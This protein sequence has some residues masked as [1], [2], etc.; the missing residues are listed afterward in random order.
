MKA[1]REAEWFGLERPDGQGL[2]APHRRARA[3]TVQRS[4]SPAPPRSPSP[5]STRSPTSDHE[6]VGVVTRPDAPAGRG[7]RLVAEPGRRSAPR[8]SA[9]PCSSPAHPRDPEF[10]AALRALAPDCCPVVAYGAL[11]P[12]ARARHPAARLGQPALLRAAGLARRRAGAARD[13]GRRRGHRRDHVPDRQ[14][15]RRRPDLRRDDRADPARPTP[16]AT[17]S[18]RLAEGGA[19]L[20]VAT[21]DGIEDG[22]ARGPRRS[23]PRA[24]ASRPRSASTTPASTGPSPPSPSTARSGPAPRRPAP[25]R[26][27]TASGSSSARSRSPTRCWRPAS[28]G[29]AKTEVLVGTGTHRGPARRGAGRSAASRCPPPTG[30][31]AP[32]SASVPRSRRVRCIAELGVY[33][34]RRMMRGPSLGSRGSPR[35][36]SESVRTSAS[37]PGSRPTVDPAR[38]A[39]LD[40]L[41][42]V[43]VDGAYT[44]L[45][46]PAVLR[47]HRLERP[48]RG[49]RHRARL[50]HDPPARAPTTRSWPPASTG[51]CP[52]SRPRCSTRCGSAPTSCSRCGCPTTP[53][54]APPSTWSAPGSA[55]APAASPTRCCARS[56]STTS[57]AWIG[58]VAPDPRASPTRYAAIAYSHPALGRR[59]A[60]RGGRR[61]PSCTTCSPPTTSPR[62]SPWSPGPGRSTRDELPGEPTPYS[63]YGV[64][65]PG[66][67]PG[68]V[69]AVAEGRAGVQ[70]E[71]SQLVAVGAGRRAARGPR[72]ALARPVRR[73]RRQG[74]AARRAGRRARRRAGRHR[75]PAA[76]RRPGPPRAARRRPGVAGV[77]TA[78]GTARAVPPRGVRPGPGRRPVHRARR[79]APPARGALAA[80]ARRPARRWCCCSAS[81]SRAAL[82]LV[83]PGGVVLYAT[84]SPVLSETSRRG[85]ARCSAPAP[86]SAL[87][88]ARAAVRPTSPTAPARCP[89]PSSSGRTG[90]APTR[91][92]WRCSA[93]REL[94]PQSSTCRR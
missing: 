90:T 10:Q 27:T 53:R 47:Q 41:K 1:I 11:L 28:C 24:S 81:W 14:G 69:P 76:P 32:A 30:P 68:A 63:P 8:S 16:P 34:V 67:D 94:S 2:A 37:R 23:R 65:L 73:S 12:A 83:R 31:A 22:D 50:R 66:G 72:R 5:P 4:S 6:L 80:H 74:R 77:V 52:R 17:C 40:V 85:R 3:L 60:A 18:A 84:C 59:R 56:P 44:N 29:S 91:C 26:R 89:A 13:L 19:G 43:R 42:A 64:V 51:R 54:S 15:A 70:D 75:A 7:R 58:R 9:Y 38:L 88:D 57:T 82:D 46:L 49:V 61:T 92:S 78:D 20:L 62:G 48:R 55:P 35:G 86:T 33:T 71:G 36:M 25:G 87:E 45:V 21:L 39:A 79:A 93:G